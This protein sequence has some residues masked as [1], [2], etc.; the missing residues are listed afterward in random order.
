MFRNSYLFSQS[1]LSKIHLFIFGNLLICVGLQGVEP[2]PA[3]FR[4][5]A[6]HT[7]DKSSVHCRAKHRETNNHS[8]SHSPQFRVTVSPLL[9]VFGGGGEAGKAQR[10]PTQT[11]EEHANSTQKSPGSSSGIII[12][13]PQFV[14][15]FRFNALFAEMIIE[16]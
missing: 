8:H 5:E 2:I 16:R 4:W 14:F 15:D 11:Q 9:H 3:D 10:K 12:K 7:L 13:C 6:G 1:F